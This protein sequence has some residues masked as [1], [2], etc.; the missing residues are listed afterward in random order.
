MKKYLSLTLAALLVVKALTGCAGQNHTPQPD[1]ISDTSTSIRTLKSGEAPDNSFRGEDYQ[2]LLALKLDGYE[3]MSVSDFQNKI[4]TRTDTAEYKNLLERFSKSKI[5]YELK[6]SDETASFLFYVLE[7]LTAEKWKTRDYDGYTETVF[8]YPAD[9]ASL[10]YS[11]TLTILNADTLTVREY[12]TARLNVI[13]GMQNMLSDRTAEELRDEA[14]ML[15]V[16]QADTD[17]LIQRLQTEEIGIAVEFAYFPPS[18]PDKENQSSHLQNTREQETRNFPNGTDE[19]YRSLLAL[20]TPNYQD[21]PL[22]D[23]NKALLEWADKDYERMERIGEDTARNDFKAVLTNEELSFIKLTVYL[24]GMENGKYIQS[25]YTGLPEEDP[26]I[27]EYL[28]QKMTEKNGYAAWCSLYY[29]IS[30]HISDKNTVTVGERD[31]QIEDT[32][33]AIQTFW[34]HTDI[35]SMLKMSESD[36]VK[37]LEKIA[38]RYRTD[39]TAITV[40]DK[41]V[42]FECMDEREFAD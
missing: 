8:P 26:I 17:R 29:R 41:Q 4:W 35:E 5:L 3:D 40:N 28:P 18:S 42:Q 39:R 12:N 27:D 16:I 25:S 9:Q 2:K 7:P 15:A 6:D 33:N 38:A 37:E 20:K 1:N 24:S 11:F 13:S 19:D 36:V 32:R 30:Y 14:S 22:A 21:M 23:F 34:D 31:R 10:E